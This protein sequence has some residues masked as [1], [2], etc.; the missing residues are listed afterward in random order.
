MRSPRS[1]MDSDPALQGP[2]AGSSSL[3]IEKWWRIFTVPEGLVQKAVRR[4]Q[5]ERSD[6]RFVLER[7]QL[8]QWEYLLHHPRF[9]RRTRTFTSTMS[10][11][12]Q[13]N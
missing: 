13:Y 3:S 12:C 1:L 7:N 5:S 8:H 11:S 9:R 6:H 2:N 4:T 10:G